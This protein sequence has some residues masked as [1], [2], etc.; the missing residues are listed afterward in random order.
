MNTELPRAKKPRAWL[1]AG[2]VFVL[3]FDL[4][5]AWQRRA[6]AYSSEL[7]GHPDE[8]GHYVSG[9]MAHDYLAHGI[10]NSPLKFAEEFTGITRRPDMVSSLR[11]FMQRKP[12]GCCRSVYQ[13]RRSCC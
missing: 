13:K 7:G 3:A 11:P 5:F 9:L 1:I 4:A 10:Y 12:P 8:A 2:I 6:G